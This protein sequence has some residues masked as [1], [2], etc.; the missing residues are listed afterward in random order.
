MDLERVFLDLSPEVEQM[1]VENEIDLE[2]ALRE[3]GLDARLSRAANPAKSSESQTK[4]VSLVLLASAAV[5]VAAT[6]LLREIIQTVSRR[7]VVINHRKLLPVEDSKGNV[8][9]DSTGNPVMQW[10][11][12]PTVIAPSGTTAI[13]QKLDIGGPMGIK[14]AY[15]S[16]EKG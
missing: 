14:I 1:L 15:S 8:V 11:D 2:A 7:S 3:R 5:I 16:T 13:D 9:Q 12:V 6:P 10:V 4:D